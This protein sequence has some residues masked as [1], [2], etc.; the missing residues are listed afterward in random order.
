MPVYSEGDEKMAAIWSIGAGGASLCPAAPGSRGH[1]AGLPGAAGTA[2]ASVTLRLP[3]LAPV[4]GLGAVPRVQDLA[5][6]PSERLSAGN[7][8]DSVFCLLQFSHYNKNKKIK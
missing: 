4:G 6:L 5:K 3:S 7:L 8:A 2:P 1:M